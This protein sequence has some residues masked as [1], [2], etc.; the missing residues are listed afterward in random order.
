LAE[1][2]AQEQRATPE[3]GGRTA[4]RSTAS[5]A[6]AR[7][8]PWLLIGGLVLFHAANNWVWLVDNVTW[9]GWDKARHLTQSL[10][11]AQMLSPITLRSVFDVMVA[12]PIRPPLVPASAAIVYWLFG[13]TADNATMI[14]VLYMAIALAAT[15]GLGRRWGSSAAP[16]QAGFHRSDGSEESIA[17]LQ[18]GGKR[19]SAECEATGRR[20]GLVSVALLAA[21]PMFYAMSRYFYLEFALTA[22]VALTIYLLLTTEGFRKRG[23]SLLFGLSW[24]LGM[25][26]KRTF[27]VFLVG[28]LLV[29]ILSSGLLPLLWQRLKQRPRLHW[30]NGLVALVG[31]LALAALWYLPNRETVQTLILGNAL[32][33]L[34]WLLAALAIYFISLPSAPL[35]NALSAVFL[36]AGLAS[37]WYLARIEF[38]QRM[39]LYGYGVNDPR[40]RALQLNRLDTYLYYLRKLASEH[41]S[42]VLFVTVMVVVAVALIVTVRRQ[43]SVR[44]TVQRIRPEGWVVVTWLGGSY[45]LLTLSIYQE[46]RAFT[47]VLPAV[48]LLF[49]AALFKLSSEAPLPGTWTAPDRP[50][51]G[52][53]VSGGLLGL[54]LA[55]ALVQFF[56]LTYE[57]VHRLLPPKTFTVPLLGAT[58][59][60]AQGVYIQLPD[61]GQTDRGYWIEPDV[62]RRMEQRR[63]ALGQESL[64]L[65]LL[66]N[67]SQI[68]A[69][70]FVYLILT[71][72]PHLRVEGLIDQFNDSSPYS[73]LFA[74]DY[75]AIKRE[76]A[77]ANRS[78]EETIAQILD[79]PPSLL[80]QAFELECSYPLP[81]GS[82]VYLYRQRSHLPEDYPVQYVTDLATHLGQR[83][84]PGDAILLTPLELVGP[85]VSQYTGPAEVEVAPPTEGELAT[86]AAQHRRVLLVL[87]DAAAGQMEGLAQDWLNRN[88]FRATHEW[89]GSL[90]V[91]IYGTVAGSPAEDPSET[92]GAFLGEQIELAGTDLPGASWRRGDVLP[93]TLFWRSGPGIEA[94]YTVFVHLLDEDGQLVAQTDS[95]PV[96]GSRPTS[97]WGEGETIVDRHGLPLPD[98]LPSGT[99]QL[100][101]GMYLPS[102][103]ERLLVADRRGVPLGDSIPLGQVTVV[104]P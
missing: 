65:G 95:A 22:M 81:D 67:T 26:T 62:L 49:G 13:R 61:E 78:Q 69:G 18:D 73:R 86:V 32:F 99:Y 80:A 82:T 53:W 8:A 46:S 19:L 89:V 51:R 52:R 7:L 84:Q 42:F 58:S 94:D 76:N 17:A 20:L 44:R 77:N 104:S 10:N 39:I 54:V 45:V 24:G 35:S 101:A 96:G 50:G 66:V 72:Y 6:V 25:L 64:S 98:D 85:F 15:Y 68:N 33:G 103:G 27:A 4:L 63:L 92:I 29:V 90:Q 60:W 88:G 9:T 31:G 43:G 11:Y 40:G 71:Q 38:V 91:I 55:F 74:H 1:S 41:L 21:F 12:D 83:T 36:A 2:G 5:E 87:G 100:L 48:A 79:A 70:P 37:T 34:W 59:S 56:A 57:P 75:L 16:P 23:A 28:P 30:K 14:N 3:R 47:P 102:T 97:S 93:L